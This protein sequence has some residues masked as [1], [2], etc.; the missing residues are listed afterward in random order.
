M[1]RLVAAFESADKSAQSI[2]LG[3][4]PLPVLS[5]SR[6]I[7]LQDLRPPCLTVTALRRRVCAGL[8]NVTVASA[9]RQFWPVDAHLDI[10]SLSWMRCVFRVV[11][12]AVLTSQLFSNRTKRD[13][14]ILLLGIV[15][16][17]AAHAGQ[18][19]QILIG[20][21]ILALAAS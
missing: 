10:A 13:I 20:D 2:I 8:E 15:K 5:F 4:L 21:L 11:T 18:V 19:M 16:T 12:K 14:K 1:R 3:S 6:E 9:N 17:G 7:L